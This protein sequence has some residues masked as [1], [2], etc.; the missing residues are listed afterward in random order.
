MHIYFGSSTMDRVNSLAHRLNQNLL[1]V[2]KRT[3][4]SGQ[5][6]T[7]L[8]SGVRSQFE[9]GAVTSGTTSKLHE[10]FLALYSKV[11]ASGKSFCYACIGYN[12]MF[13]VRQNCEKNHRSPGPHKP[14]AGGIR[15][16]SKQG[17]AFVQ[18]KINATN[19]C[20]NLASE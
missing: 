18:P 15:I 5:S 9:T 20:D 2:T 11:G 3:P 13:C 1:S 14:E 6:P 12:G 17:K 7:S 8:T 4:S 16:L 10:L 19:L